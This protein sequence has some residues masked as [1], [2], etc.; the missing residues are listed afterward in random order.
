MSVELNDDD[1][2]ALL[3]GGEEKGDPIDAPPRQPKPADAITKYIDPAALQRDVAIGASI[4]EDA[5][6]H[7]AMLAYYGTKAAHARRQRDKV[8]TSLEINEAR[9]AEE[10]RAKYASEGSKLT[11]ARLEQLVRI[12]PKYGTLRG[13]LDE[14]NAV[15][16]HALIAV[17]SFKQRG[18]MLIQLSAGARQE[19]AGDIAL[20]SISSK[21][22][23]AVAAV[24]GSRAA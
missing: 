8:K 16:E 9:I 1:L 14:A 15:L 21:G 12:H 18:S 20:S 6:S 5:R 3:T 4:D 24:R 19:R 11:E 13:M 23:A 22:E 17:E 2:N 10:I 7:A